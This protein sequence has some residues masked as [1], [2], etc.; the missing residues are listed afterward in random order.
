MTCNLRHPMGLRHPVP[1]GL[2]GN[3][4]PCTWMVSIYVHEWFYLVCLNTVRPFLLLFVGAVCCSALQQCVAEWCSSE[5]QCVATMRCSIWHLA[6]CDLCVLR[7][8]ALVHVLF[9]VTRRCT[10]SSVSQQKISPSF[11]CWCV[12]WTDAFSCTLQH[13]SAHC[14]IVVQHTTTPCSTQALVHVLC[15]QCSIVM[16]LVYLAT[17]CNVL[18]LTDATHCNALWHT[19]AHKCLS[20]FSSNNYVPCSHV[21]CLPRNT[22]SL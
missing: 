15:Q 8:R 14:Y 16:F 19:V 9:V 2:D 5:L 3:M 17:H 7:E 10:G 18:Q 6:S 4:Y 13:T 21:S 11:S 1:T 12:T 20:V 22:T